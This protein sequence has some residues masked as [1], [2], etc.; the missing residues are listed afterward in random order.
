[1]RKYKATLQYSLIQALFCAA[2]GCIMIFTSVFLLDKGFTNT[3]VGYVLAGGAIFSVIFQPVLGGI[4]DSSKKMILREISIACMLFAIVLALAMLF[5]GDSYWLNTIIFS[6]LVGTVQ[7]STP[8]I[9]ALGTF[10]MERGINIDFGIGRGMGS[11]AYALTSF[12]VGLLIESFNLNV[13]LYVLIIVYILLIFVVSRFGFD[14][15]KDINYDDDS[16]GV[17]KTS[18]VKFFKIYPNFSIVLVG[19]VLVFISF[20]MVNNFMF[21]ILTN[22]GYGSKEMGTA[23]SIA[24]VSELPT[25]FGLTLLRKKFKSGML[26][27]ISAIFI[28]LR[29]LLT[30]LANS[31][32]LLYFSAFTQMLGF[33]LFAGASVYYVYHVIEPQNNARGQSLMTATGVLGSVIASLLG[34]RLIDAYGVSTMLYVGTGCALLGALLIIIKTEKGQ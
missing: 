33:A 18:I 9:Y 30:L 16:V 21:Q 17:A 24:A 20:S 31:L 4:A 8:I 2:L 27:K 14:G 28:F 5:V 10:Y 25:L 19:F 1:M 12:T 34:G 6:L 29:V 15:I 13:I 11:L 3:Q 22:I 23:I 26:M 7:V 32:G